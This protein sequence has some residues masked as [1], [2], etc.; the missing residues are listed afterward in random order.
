MLTNAA[1][2]VEFPPTDI[3]RLRLAGTDSSSGG[4]ASG[5]LFPRGRRPGLISVVSLRGPLMIR[6]L[7]SA[8]ARVAPAAAIL[9]AVAA[10]LQ[11]TRSDPAGSTA[12]AQAAGGAAPAG[13]PAVPK[14]PLSPEEA[15]KTIRVP[16]GLKVELVACEPDV[17]SPVA[18]AFDE[19]GRMYVVE[20]SD[21]PLGPMKGRVKLLQSTKGDG[22]FDK[23]TVFAE[24]LNYPNG[25]MPYKGG[26]FVTAAPDLLYL[27][28]TDG[29]GRADVRRVIFTGFAEANPQHRFNS[30]MMGLDGWVYVADGDSPK[31]VRRGDDP[32]APLIPLRGS[33]FRFHPET[34]EFE[35]IAGRSQYGHSFDDWGNRYICDNS[36][37][38]RRPMLPLHYLKRNPYLAVPSVVEDI[39]D[40]GSAC[41]V[42]PSSKTE[43]RFNDLHAANHITSACSIHIY[44]G[45]ALPAE[46]YGNALVC[47]PVHNLIHRDILVQQ[48]HRTVAKRAHEEGEFLTSTDNW[49]RPTSLYTG[50]DGAL[51]VTDMYRAV[52][53][54]P[55][56]IPLDV[57]KRIDLRAGSELGRIWRVT[58][59]TERNRLRMN[60]RTASNDDLIYQLSHPNAWWRS[61][62]HRLLIERKSQEATWLLADQV[63]DGGRNERATVLALGILEYMNAADAPFYNKV[64]SRGGAAARRAMCISERWGGLTAAVAPAAD[65]ENRA[66]RFQAAFSLGAARDD[67]A[68]AALASIAARD[69]DDRWFRIAVLSSV[70]DRS[71]KL[72]TQIKEKHADFL[73]APGPGAIEFVRELS[74]VVGARRDEA[75]VVELIQLAAG[76]VGVAPAR[77]QL[78]ALSGLGE[79]LR[80]SG[81]GFDRYLAKADAADTFDTWTARALTAAAD[82]A[83]ELSDR[84]DAIGLLTLL[85]SADS[86][87]RL[88]ALLNPKEP[89]QV[90]SAAVRALAALPGP[91]IA[92]R[93]LAGWSGRSPAVRKEVVGVLVGRADR[94]A[95]LMDALE[96][97]VVKAPD[98]EPVRREQLIR[99]SDIGVRDRARKF[100]D[101]VKPSNR[102]KLA[103]EW[104]PKVLALATDA[105]RGQAVYA[106]HCIQCHR[107]HGQGV[108]VGPDLG[109][110]SGRT[111][112]ALIV[113]ILDP[114]RAVDPQFLEYVVITHDEQIANGL[115]AAETPSSITLRQAERKEITVL[116]KDIA[117]IRTT[118]LSG[119][120]EGVEKNIT[121]QELADL[122]E[123][124]KRGRIQ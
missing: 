102:A 78:A 81:G 97:G 32:K 116:R 69:A 43:A 101:A 120:P 99:Y 82:P 50:P 29:D 59:Q 56:W 12:P 122:I 109:G 33:D 76:E 40:H 114:N 79:S 52:I 14:S 28:D 49:F 44:R 22:R 65:S 75:E 88:A 23:A 67:G 18:M 110:V 55:Q 90:Q 35:L 36:N 107:L 8:V 104:T 106:K 6:R 37:H 84:L 85:P 39:S 46:Y 74:A 1:R 54:H 42:Y 25:V 11:S 124:L 68:L 86:A 89:P 45:D 66:D 20:M 92:D 31:G 105:V 41:R 83:R 103:E 19:D 26:V 34:L 63:K 13:A 123:L 38:I 117:Q 48:G 80:R 111:R 15:L 95:K 10:A 64:A 60:R 70:P 4:Q 96:A 7:P 72:L 21:Y 108:A 5:I 47:E 113:D 77:W 121:P 87:D 118:G 115:I 53:E 2:P 51:Y 9:F 100:F 73:T 24:G 57:Q 93:L 112:E 61:T 62:A 58:V 94:A 98:L 3:T 27:K 91:A 16:T 119:M 17:V 30:P 71:A